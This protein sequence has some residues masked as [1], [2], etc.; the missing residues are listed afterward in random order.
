M[1]PQE[2]PRLLI[3]ALRGLPITVAATLCKYPQPVSQA[4]LC[5]L[6]CYS[7][8]T[9][10]IALHRLEEFQMLSHSAEGWSVT[11]HITL[12]GFS[13]PEWLQEPDEP[14]DN[15]V[16]I[17]PVDKPVEKGRKFSDSTSLTTSSTSSIKLTNKKLEK[18]LLLVDPESKFK[19]EPELETDPAPEAVSKPNTK[20]PEMI[21]ECHQAAINSGIGEPKATVV[22]K[23]PYSTPEMIE[24]FVEEALAD[25]Q[26]IGLAIHR[27]ENYDPDKKTQKRKSQERKPQSR[28]DRQ[29]YVTGK[30]SDWINH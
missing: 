16:D 4:H 20:S 11:V 10:S 14:V 26:K 28:E 2:D 13:L 29:R 3:V 1:N 8:K 19:T 30:Y 24:Q 7:D 18:N 17:C 27:L 23:L 12:L 9:M 15:P 22:A 6:L 25:G 5:N 21:R